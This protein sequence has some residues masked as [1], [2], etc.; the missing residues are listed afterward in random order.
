[1][2]LAK[3]FLSPR[4]CDVLGGS[5]GLFRCLQQSGVIKGQLSAI[6][7]PGW[8]PCLHTASSHQLEEGDLSSLSPDGRRHPETSL[9]PSPLFPRGSPLRGGAR[10]WPRAQ[11]GL[12]EPR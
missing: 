6:K 1:M 2:T 5:E 10:T 9:L 7:G 11:E 8:G 12:G 4:A 3:C